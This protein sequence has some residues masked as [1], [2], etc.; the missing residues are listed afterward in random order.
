V[1]RV[2]RSRPPA[3]FRRT[4]AAL[5]CVLALAGTTAS[6]GLLGSDD[7]PDLSAVPIQESSPAAEPDDPDLSRF[8]DQELDWSSCQGDL[9]C[10]R[11]QVPLDYTKPGGETISLS[12]LKVPAT[13]GDQRIGSLVVNPG[14][15]GA[16]AIDY[17]ARADSAFGTEVLAAFDVVGL[18]PRGVGESTPIDCLSD[19]E[20]DTMIASDPDP[21]TPAEV[22][23]GAALVKGL[24]QGCLERSGALTAHVS[25]E[26][27][28]RDMDILRGVLGEQRLAYFGASYGTYLGATYADLFP[29]RV[30]RMVLD[31]AIDPTLTS[32]QMSL[33]QAK[34]FEVALEAY[35]S[36][37]VDGGD[38]YL[39]DSVEEGLTTIEE[40]LAELDS[41]PIPGDGSRDLT[42]GLAVLGIW[43]PLYNRSY[44]TLLDQA[45]S[46]GLTGNGH[47]LLSFADLYVGRGKDGYE[48]NSSEAIYAV[49]CLDHDDVVTAEEARRLEPRFVEA[50]PVFGRVFAAGLSAC[51]DW[52]VQSGKKPHPLTADGSAPI[53]VVGTSRDPATPLAWAE[54]LARQLESAVLVRRD[55]D[56]HTGYRAG[57]Q[58]VDDAVEKYLVEGDVPDGDVDC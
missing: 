10:A 14:G 4:A 12:V 20:L 25:T 48:D 27:A 36:D 35:V 52:P 56:G 42:E 46:Q 43:A 1:T 57:N 33:V 26:E 55:G 58:C 41:T 28:A 22:R 53:M 32:T 39:G 8:Y 2:P 49:N 34:G 17:A 21:D 40:F 23:R 30:G 18:D 11:L 5:G 6:C 51:N 19:D 50:S 54:S 45:L 13:H 44:W 24:G 38:C 9:R 47:A 3:R 31:G 16:S 29:D 7:E 15:P 37:C